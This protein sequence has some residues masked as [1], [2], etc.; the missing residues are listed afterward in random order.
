MKG[1][2]VVSQ[3]GA[4]MHY[5]VPRIFENLGRL[6]RLNTDI[7]AARG[8]PR[9][10]GMMP[11]RALPASLR[12]LAGRVPQGIPPHKIR[13]FETIGLQSV[14]RRMMT[15]TI[16]VD[17]QV[18][19]EAGRAFSRAV[20]A[21][22]FGEAR[23]FYGMSGEC[24]EQLQAARKQGLWSAVEQVIAPRSVADRLVALETE[25]HP[26]WEPAPDE[27]PL[28][29]EYAQR[30]KDEWE[31]ADLVICASDFVRDGIAAAGGPVERCVVVPYG[32][33]A[34]V[35]RNFSKP[36]LPGRLRVL[37]VG[38]ACLRKGT[39]DVMASALR[40]SKEASFRFVGPVEQLPAARQRE[41][42]D[43]L[44]VT[45]QVPRSEIPA[46]YDWAD[47]FFLPSICEGSATVIYEA[48]AA[49]LPVV[50]TPNAGSVVRDGVDGFVCAA[51]DVDAL[52]DR[53]SRLSADPDLVVWMGRNARARAAE[54]DVAAYGRRLWAAFDPSASAEMEKLS[55]AV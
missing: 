8:W 50:T 2:V 21:E 5:A 53:I 15:P 17:T 14:I 29:G 25:R 51:G 49:G 36:R 37:T 18:A 26:G 46:Q 31:A 19:L 6:E 34:R 42:A 22:G 43:A 30:E 10:L 7:C 11:R 45:G 55:C 20:V 40:L 48:L 32:V 23:A 39:P 28:A 44:T 52:C 38:A 35:V 41:L 33:D 3:L 1:T 13:C 47:I 4:R 27:V 24:L 54:F 16:A 12:R 9:A